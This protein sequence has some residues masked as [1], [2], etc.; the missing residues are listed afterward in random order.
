MA[1]IRSIDVIWLL[2]LTALGVL[3][4]LE[5][6]PSPWE[7]VALAGLGAVQIAEGRLGW[8]ATWRGAAFG[9]AVKLALCYLLVWETGGIESSYFLIFLL[10]IISAASI[11][12]LRGAMAA[13]LGGSLLYLTFLLYVLEGYYVPPDGQREI[14]TRVLFFFVIAVLVN[15]LA[16]ENRLK[17]ESLSQAN[18]ELS[19]AQAEVRRS[20]RLAALGQLS[21]GL[22]HEMRNPLGVIQASAELLAKNVAAENEV[23]RE[24]AGFIGA[25]VNR[26]NALVTRFLDFARPSKVHR[27]VQDLNPTVERAYQQIEETI[28]NE[29]ADLSVVKTLRPVPRFAFDATLIESS[30][31]NLLLNAKEASQPGGEIRIETGA[32]DG[33]AFIA[34]SDHGSGISPDTL[35]DIFN[36]FFTTKPTGV[37]LGLAMV[38]KFID[39]H[40][41]SIQVDS[42]PAE[43]TVFRISLPLNTEV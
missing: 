30:V 1:R 3:I 23:A 7:W 4:L 27:E 26:T 12:G 14:A 35:E 39:S 24:V 20:E 25:E 17:T 38:S 10:P 43:G 8:Q 9:I 29:K 32:S 13:T 18:R 34:V 19:E 37:G 15:R 16:T 11:F 22:A 21:A 36:P 42:T 6:A 40:N 33:H 28:R 2:F 31:L 5:S 41:G